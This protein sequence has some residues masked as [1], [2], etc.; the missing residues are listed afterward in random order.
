MNVKHF[1]FLVVLLFVSYCN[2]NGGSDAIRVQGGKLM[3]II[4]ASGKLV[5]FHPESIDGV[6][7]CFCTF[8]DFLGG[9]GPH[10]MDIDKDGNIYIL[11]GYCD[12]IRKFDRRG[13][14]ISNFP[15]RTKD[16]N[17]YEG[18]LHGIA[19]DNDGNIFVTRRGR[20]GH[21]IMEF[22][23]QGKL[24]KIG[25]VPETKKGYLIHYIS[26]FISV[27]KEGRIFITEGK[28]SDKVNIYD[29][30]LRLVTTIPQPFKYFD[31]YVAQK[32]LGNDIYFRRG[33]YLVK[34]SLEEYKQKRKTDKVAVLPKEILASWYKVEDKKQKKGIPTEFGMIGFDKDTCFYFYQ[35][36]HFG[37]ESDLDMCIGCQ[38]LKYCLREGKLE[39]KGMVLLDLLRGKEECSNR[40]L[41]KPGFPHDFF[42]SGDGIIYWIHGTV[43][44]IRV[45]EIIMD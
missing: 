29:L 2:A 11:D 3:D 13:K 15:I 39:K 17:Y 45:S 20:G 8:L 32:Q 31:K 30:E 35:S 43:D 5:D 7:S 10:Q 24:L 12:I 4:V 9:V 28:S 22:S 1:L 41:Y 14:W 19:V 40:A 23:Y 34:T 37:E 16:G 42:V 36:H 27:D 18:G 26:N 38:I 33:R 25:K 21:W 44:T 6:D